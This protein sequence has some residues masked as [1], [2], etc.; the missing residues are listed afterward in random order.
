MIEESGGAIV[1]DDGHMSDAPTTIA[2]VDDD[3]AGE[4][5]VTI[6]SLRTRFGKG[7]VTRGVL[8]GRRAMPDTP[9]L[10]D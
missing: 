9:M 10:P 2:L 7:A 5:D 4:L 1:W 6:D 3:H 8:V